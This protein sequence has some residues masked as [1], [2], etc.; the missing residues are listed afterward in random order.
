MVTLIKW[1]SLQ[2]SVRKFIPKKICVIDPSSKLVS[3]R[4][5]TVLS[6]SPSA[7]VPWWI[8][9]HA[10]TLGNFENEKLNIIFV[11]FAVPR[12]AEVSGAQ[13]G[14]LRMIW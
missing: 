3:T 12:Q 7:R 2:K 11:I 8:S 10:S 13:T 5:S 1:S 6:P 14:D 9:Q 4:R